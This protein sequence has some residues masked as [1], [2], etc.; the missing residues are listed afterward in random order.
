MSRNEPITPEMSEKDH[1]VR[2]LF[3]TFAWGTLCERIAQRIGF[4]RTEIFKSGATTEDRLK[5]VEQIVLMRKLFD[6]LYREVG[7]DMP[8]DFRKAFE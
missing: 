3:E 2:E 7:I 1:V 5:Y 6:D 8:A 4:L